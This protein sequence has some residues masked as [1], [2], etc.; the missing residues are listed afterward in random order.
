MKKFIKQVLLKS[1]I[2][3]G[4][5]L[6]TLLMSAI[7]ILFLTS[8]DA[9][10]SSKNHQTKAYTK[11]ELKS[12]QLC[13]GTIE[14]T[15]SFIDRVESYVG[16]KCMSILEEINLPTDMNKQ[17]PSNG[18]NWAP[19]TVDFRNYPEL[20]IP[21]KAHITGL[22][23]ACVVNNA[24]SYFK[25]NPPDRSAL[26]ANIWVLKSCVL[27]PN[28]VAKGAVMQFQFAKSDGLTGES[29]EWLRELLLKNIPEAVK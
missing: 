25:L 1:S 29:L 27:E 26:V 9:F 20:D 24:D 3:C 16:K 10:A 13:Y 19:G 6:R 15:K 21:N 12:Q 11:A 4:M 8:P 22:R 14:L 18:R 5:N 2:T 23:A 17:G 7:S 28:E